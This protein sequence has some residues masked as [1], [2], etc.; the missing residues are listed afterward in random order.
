MWA[1]SVVMEQHFLYRQKAEWQ[2]NGRDDERL[3]VGYLN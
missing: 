2:C 1:A 3:L